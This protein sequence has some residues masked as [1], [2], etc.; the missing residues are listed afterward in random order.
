MIY[1]LGGSAK[2]FAVIGVT[3]PSGSTCTCTNGTKTLKAKG[4]S[5]TAIFNVPSTG[6][7]TVTA[8]NGDKTA[9]K[10]VSI[11]AEGQVETVELLYAL[12]IFKEGEGA[13]TPM[14]VQAQSGVSA[15]IT[16]DVI[17]LNY[18]YGAT[19]NIVAEALNKTA[20]DLTNFNTLYIDLV[21][22]RI[23]NSTTYGTHYGVFSNDAV[24]GYISDNFV[25]GE[26]VKA[27]FTR[28]V[29]TVDLS[30]ITGSYFVG[31]KGAMSAQVYNIW[32]E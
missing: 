28:T 2:M 15:S 6:T 12:Y 4:T 19:Q 14:T 7:W 21:A 30:T 27:T 3:Y 1:V 13:V 5:G 23:N 10:S 18:P 9:S 31:V 25:A 17:T 32:L 29:K 16:D 22:I 11:T 8:T 24:T 20:I 26:Q